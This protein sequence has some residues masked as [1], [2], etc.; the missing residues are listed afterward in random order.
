MKEMIKNI[1]IV[2]DNA[3]IRTS[4]RLLLTSNGY[5][6]AEVSNGTD[7][8]AYV[9]KTPP[10]MVFLDIYMPDIN[11][12]Q[13]LEEIVTEEVE[14]SIIMITG[15]STMET[16]ISAIKLGARDYITKPLL[17]HK[18]L[19]I[20]EKCFNEGAQ[21]ASTV[22]ESIQNTSDHY[23]L[24]GQSMEM[25]EVFKIIGSVV[26]TGNETPVL[27]LGESGTGKELVA[28]QI[29]FMGNNP[30][31]PFIPLNMTALPDNL[32]ESELFG[33]KK[34]AFTGANQNQAGKFEVANSG[35]IYLDEIGSISM[36]IQLK[37]LRVLQEREFV[38][39]GGHHTQPVKARIIASTNENLD[40]LIELG[41]FRKDLFFRLNVVTID[42]P[43]LRD[44]KNDIPLL[45]E[46]FVQKHAEL[47]QRSEPRIPIK[48][49]EYF[50]SYDWPGNVRELENVVRR[51]LVT[52]NTNIINPGDVN[53]QRRAVKTVQ[54]PIL[55]TNLQ[56]ARRKLNYEF[57]KS[58]VERTLTECNGIVSQAAAQAGVNRQLFY[59]LL[60]KHGLDP[61]SYQ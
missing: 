2:D 33:Y 18:V 39:L 50:K 58:F 11:G 59:R 42:L 16:A 34:G 7:A 23:T 4:L 53:I 54:I 1:L 38:Q 14:T 31:A 9:R 51:A 37:L 8:L 25:I 45:L 17:P 47:L 5:Q 55:S 24:I 28:R 6:V 13:V 29:H 36:G 21:K 48:T 22:S 46:Y 43:P 49:I 3:S 12:I 30:N 44:R 40:S 20:V 27:I 35:S 57:E 15:D 60:K 19:G 52:S 56:E 41:L 61:K 10:M 32:L 26:K